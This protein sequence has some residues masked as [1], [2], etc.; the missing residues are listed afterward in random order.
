MVEVNNIY[1][2]KKNDKPKTQNSKPE[3]VLPKE[4]EKH[5]DQNHETTNDSGAIFTSP[6]RYFKRLSK[7]KVKKV[8]GWS[9]KD[10]QKWFDEKKF[11]SNLME[12]LKPDVNGKVLFQMFQILQS[13]PEF[14]Y[15]SLRSDSNN[16]LFLKDVAIFSFELSALFEDSE[17]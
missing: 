3:T 5:I 16:K 10:I 8:I 2:E 7:E 15:T 17:F 1:G 12:N 11:N 9:E 14:F 13:T 4:E 6:Q